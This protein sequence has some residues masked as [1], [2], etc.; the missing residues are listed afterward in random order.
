M[1]T[2]IFIKKL[3][4]VEGGGGGQSPPLLTIHLLSFSILVESEERG[5]IGPCPRTEH[6]LGLGRVCRGTDESHTQGRI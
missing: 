1:L 5:G 4:F 3:T 2:E 6:P